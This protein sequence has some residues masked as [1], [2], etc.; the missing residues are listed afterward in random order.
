MGYI[1]IKNII[2]LLFTLFF[3][4]HVYADSDRHYK[5][6]GHT[7]DFG[8]KNI[9]TSLIS[10][11]CGKYGACSSVL[12]LEEARS[13]VEQ[14]LRPGYKIKSIKDDRWQYVVTVVDKNNNPYEE[15]LVHKRSGRIRSIRIFK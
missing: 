9:R 4:S 3:S 12:T 8:P 11:R 5:R 2:I 1:V 14:S 10:E 6:E 15:L 13:S 7:D